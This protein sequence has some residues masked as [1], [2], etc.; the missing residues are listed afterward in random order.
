MKTDMSQFFINEIFVDIYVNVNMHKTLAKL[1][2]ECVR[3]TQKNVRGTSG[4]QNKYLL[5]KRKR[6]ENHSFNARGHFSNIKSIV[7]YYSIAT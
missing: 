3:T 2:T 7:N 1:Y 4:I 6:L 5:P